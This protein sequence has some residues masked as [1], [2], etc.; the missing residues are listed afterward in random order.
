[1]GA[2]TCAFG[3]QRAIFTIN[4]IMHA[5]HMK[6][7]DKELD[8]VWVQ[9]W[10]IKKFSEPIVFWICTRATRSGRDAINTSV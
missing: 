8:I 7:L 10:I 5:S 6:I 2:L 9:C 3:S 1:M 4:V